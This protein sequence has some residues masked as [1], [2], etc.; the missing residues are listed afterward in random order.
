MNA[1]SLDYKVIIQKGVESTMMESISMV[2]AIRLTLMMLQLVLKPEKSVDWQ[3]LSL[4]Q[5]D[6]ICALH[7]ARRIKTIDQHMG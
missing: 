4:E 1:L 3:K 7:A 2:V 5:C 6:K